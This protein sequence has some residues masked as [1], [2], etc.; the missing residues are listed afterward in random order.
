MKSLRAAILAV[1][2]VAPALRAQ[3]FTLPAEIVTA[4]RTP[5]PA[6]QAAFSVTVLARRIAAESGRPPGRVDGGS[7][8]EAQ[9][10][11]SASSTNG[12]VRSIVI[13][14]WLVSGAAVWR[15]PSE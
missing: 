10:E 8:D 1:C 7:L 3:T 11:A 15:E 6:E 4:S 13:G 14:E 9:A 5:Q 2:C 12:E